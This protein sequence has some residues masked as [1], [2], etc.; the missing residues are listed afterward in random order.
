MEINL[1]NL[2]G[3]TIKLICRYYL[4][5]LFSFLTKQ[6]SLFK[7]RSLDFK[8][9][10]QGGPFTLQNLSYLKRVPGTQYF[11]KQIDPRN[12]ETPFEPVHKRIFL[13]TLSPS[14]DSTR[15]G[16]SGT[17]DRGERGGWQRGNAKGG[18]LYPFDWDMH[19]SSVRVR[20]VR[21]GARG[22]RKGEQCRAWLINKYPWLVAS[23]CQGEGVCC[24]AVWS[25]TTLGGSDGVTATDADA[26]AIFTC[27]VFVFNFRKV[28]TSADF[29]P[30]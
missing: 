28:R 20:H 8:L 25:L 14:H 3:K 6:N 15:G 17:A 29:G 24:Q 11:T 9:Q 7:I 4:I 27:H 30:R 18:R 2:P 5:F 10:S 19:V 23:R 1:R 16:D 22:G 13:S 26:I 21:R 12:L